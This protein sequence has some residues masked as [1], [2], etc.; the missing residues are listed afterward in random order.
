MSEEIKNA[1]IVVPWALLI[2]IILNGILAFAMMFA[3]LFVAGDFTLPLNSNYGYAFVEIFINAT[4]SVPGATFMVCVTAIMQLFCN[5]GLLASC[6]RLTW[7]F[8]RDQGLPGHQYLSK[9]S[10]SPKIPDVCFLTLL[11]SI[12]LKVHPKT[13][14]PMVAIITTA[15]ISGLLSLLV[16]P[17]TTAFTNITAISAAGL[18]SSYLLSIG[19]LLWRRLAGNIRHA[20][21]SEYQLTNTPGFELSWGPWRMPG[22]L[23]PIVNVIAIVFLGILLF[24]SF[25]PAEAAVTPANM[26]YSILVTGSVLLFSVVWYMTFGRR[27]YKGPVVDASSRQ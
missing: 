15:M 3:L 24:F 7:A 18:C 19:F 14:I 9:L 8:A 2:G 4:G 11:S 5:V 12:V 21:H 17:S 20:S 6:S 27:V 1:P 22:I 13:S 10:V 16:L 23:G 25:W 26:N